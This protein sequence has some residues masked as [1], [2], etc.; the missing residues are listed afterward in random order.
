[1]YPVGAGF[2][3]PDN[4]TKVPKIWTVLYRYDMT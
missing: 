3:D 4:S 1:M 2:S